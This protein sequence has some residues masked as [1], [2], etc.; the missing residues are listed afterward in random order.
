MLI[1]V[2]SPLCCQVAEASGQTTVFL[3]EIAWMGSKE[4]PNFEWIELYNPAE[5]EIIFENWVLKIDS[6]EIPL[7]GRI[8]PKS[9]YLLERSSDNTIGNVSADL[10]YSGALSNKGNKIELRSG[11]EVIDSLDCSLGWFKGDNSTK[12]T[13]ERIVFNA[14]PSLEHWQ[15]S[16]NPGGTPKKEAVINK[17]EQHKIPASL[18][19]ERAASIF[20][21]Q[22]TETG[23]LLPSLF[24]SLFSGAIM[25]YLK[26]NTKSL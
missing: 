12:Q 5:K 11:L 17:E 4:S 13:M 18:K 23:F 6:K 10:I 3:S 22:K 1:F 21:E 26:R 20:Q 9:F 16:L 19:K 7:K 14:P 24:I 15:N 25:L 8:S 2:L